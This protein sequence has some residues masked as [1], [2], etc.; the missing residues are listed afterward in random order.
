M[1]YYFYKNLKNKYVININL[2]Y[3]D[4]DSFILK[5]NT[6]DIYKDMSQDVD[7]YDTSNYKSDTK[8]FSTKNKK[9]IGKFKDELGG[10]IMSEF[11]G[12]RAKAYAYKYIDNN[13]EKS[14][15]KLKG[16]K[17]NVIK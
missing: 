13:I 3:M 14:D 11:V 12:L 9:V 16:V 7:I 10:K 4:A 15:K 8:L 2:L 17:K 5:I 6:E 1:Y